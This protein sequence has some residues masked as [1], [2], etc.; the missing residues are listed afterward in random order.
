M[1]FADSLYARGP[2]YDFFQ[3]VR[4]LELLRHDPAD[5][6]WAPVEDVARFRAH[7]SLNFPPSSV[8]GV[9]PP[10]D[11]R[12]VPTVT[13]NFLGLT[14]PQGALPTHYTQLVMRIAREG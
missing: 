4:L 7:Q 1:S 14:G 8:Y 6:A 11:G 10:A 2:E 12:R 3:V 9:E 13:V 5:P